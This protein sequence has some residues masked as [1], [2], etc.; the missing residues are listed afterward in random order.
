MTTG[1]T[2]VVRISQ[3][4]PELRP[5]PGKE[6]FN[7]PIQHTRTGGS[8]QHKQGLPPAPPYRQQHQQQHIQRNHAALVPDRTDA[9]E[10]RSR[11]GLA[12][13]CSHHISR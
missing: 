13:P 6:H 5:F 10:K 12:Q 7:Q 9:M 4:R 1:K 11:P 8:N 3:R 2:C